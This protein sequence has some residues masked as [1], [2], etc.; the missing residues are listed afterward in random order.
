MPNQVL[1]SHP[2]W[3]R[4]MTKAKTINIKVDKFVFEM[5]FTKHVMKMLDDNPVFQAKLWEAASKQW[6]VMLKELD[7]TIE[8][9]EKDL[10]RYSKLETP[11]E[12]E[13]TKKDYLLSLKNDFETILTRHRA[14]MA[15]AVE[16]EWAKI[17]KQNKIA[18]EFKI[19]TVFKA[20]G[21]TVAITSS[22]LALVASG[23]LNFL[24]YFTLA[25]SITASVAEMKTLSKNIDKLGKEIVDDVNAFAG[26][27]KDHPKLKKAKDVTN[28]VTFALLGAQFTR[29]F[30]S[31]N[32]K[33]GVFKTRLAL[34]QQ[35]QIKLGKDVK[36]LLDKVA[37]EK[38][39]ADKA[40]QTKMAKLE[41]AL[42][43]ML[44][45][46][47]KLGEQFVEN[48]KIADKQLA[49]L[50]KLQKA[51]GRAILTITTTV[52]SISANV[53]KIVLSA[54]VLDAASAGDAIQSIAESLSK[55]TA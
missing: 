43:A 19:K 47:S 49:E 27:I 15:K 52:V 54:A 11:S 45:K 9:A 30:T 21:R 25:R 14:G 33:I 6:K 26:D 3:F 8:S 24:A 2:N 48:E 32:K 46:V 29:S 16:A 1:I 55:E 34:I 10:F 18:N 53:T 20:L 40:S 4:L 17:R 28:V 38:G 13:E 5:E 7:S 31:I 35:K 39:K 22:I 51:T 42:N 23:G 44:Q 36:K 41:K 37:K 50:R 12:F